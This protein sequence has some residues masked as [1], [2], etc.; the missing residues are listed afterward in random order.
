MRRIN[1]VRTLVFVVVLL[2]SSY[3][4]YLADNV[5]REAQTALL[6]EIS[7]VQAGALE[8]RLIKSLA[9]TYILAHE[10]RV[11]SGY[12]SGTDFEVYAQELIKRIGG[13]SNL[14]LAPEGIVS[15]IYPLAGNERALGH[16]I[17]RDDNRRAEAWTAIESRQLTLAG[18]FTLVQ[19]G[20]AVIGRNPVFVERQGQD[21]FWGFTS[22]LI[23]LEDLLS[24]T[25]LGALAERGYRYRLSREDPNRAE[26]SVFDQSPGLQP[27]QQLPVSHE[28]H[29]PN[30]IWRLEMA[31]PQAPAT[32]PMGYIAS[33]LGALLLA[34]LGGRVYAEP[35]RLRQLVQT[36][37]RTLSLREAQ[38]RDLIEALPS[39]ILMTDS[40]GRSQLA[41]QRYA[42]MFELPLASGPQAQPSAARF[43]DGS[44]F[45]QRLEEMMHVGSAVKGVLL[46]DRNG[47]EYELDYAPVQVDAGQ[48]LHLWNYRD[49][50]QRRLDERMMRNISAERAS[51]FQL[52]PD[53]FASFDS[54]GRISQVNKAFEEAFGFDSESIVGLHCSELDA[55]LAALCEPDAGLSA[56][57][58]ARHL[59]DRASGTAIPL[60][61]DEL[62]LVRP[63]RR[64]LQRLIRF[65]NSENSLGG[66]I[67]FRDMTNQKELEQMK[68]EFL[69][70]AAHEL[71]TPMTAIYG[72]T[73]L[74][75]HADYDSELQREL[76]SS[77]HRQTSRL[78]AMLD[79]LLD[80]A[81]IE[82]RGALELSRE[83]QSLGPLVKQVIQDISLGGGSGHAYRLHIDEGSSEVLIDAGKIG[84]VLMNILSNAQKYS[85]PESPIQVNVGPCQA[86]GQPAMSIRVQDL[87]IG[88]SDAQIRH[89]FTRF[90]RADQSGAIPGTGLGMSIAWEIIE[91]HHGRI[92]VESEPGM[93]TLVTVILPCVT[94]SALSA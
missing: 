34:W 26:V 35:E 51:I 18:P 55:R 19:G 39:G 79:D 70:T 43:V 77:V 69:S 29:V 1:G 71:R 44:G 61:V 66:V 75:L 47:R 84:Q 2:A 93:G 45:P 82:S 76:L 56:I 12:F 41:N 59:S 11:T 37:T 27:D 88:M 46:Q 4:S 90:Y 53:A 30:A 32:L 31:L 14:Q 57:N 17:L 68:T 8:R 28:I 36:K 67:Y 54:Q 81:R 15:S 42:G 9:A 92:D 7:G 87:G 64:Y 21:V 63:Q 86:Q 3:W 22:V 83:P 91:L 10:V 80:L 6:T 50:T 94:D 74:L 85:S 49:V 20:V 40:D 72:Y 25:E 5:E 48:R 13:I 62:Q 60:L 33:V 23:F 16:D 89:V 24:D 78:V 38:L 65:E 58:Y 73:E 52:S